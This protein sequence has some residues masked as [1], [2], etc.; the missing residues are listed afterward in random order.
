MLLDALKFKLISQAG[1]VGCGTCCREHPGPYLVR[2]LLYRNTQRHLA[3]L[4]LPHLQER[5]RAAE[6]HTGPV[7]VVMRPRPAVPG[8]TVNTANS[9]DTTEAGSAAAA[10]PAGGDGHQLVPVP[11]PVGSVRASLGALST[12]EDCYAL[13]RFLGTTFKDFHVSSL[14][15]IAGVKAVG[16]TGTDTGSTVLLGQT[17]PVMDL[18]SHCLVDRSFLDWQVVACT[19][20]GKTIY[21]SALHCLE[22]L[23][24]LAANIDPALRNVHAEVDQW[25]EVAIMF[26]QRPYRPL[27]SSTV[28][29]ICL[30]VCA[31]LLTPNP[32]PCR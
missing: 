21:A 1:P 3:L 12:F 29:H 2:P 30:P 10:G 32:T 28:V 13:V 11:L 27:G 17:L 31:L 19:G 5:A 26:V 9:T 16:G 24:V 18:Y 8:T 6:G 20:D 25:R 15:L 7:L 22:A 23:L 14:D 4:P